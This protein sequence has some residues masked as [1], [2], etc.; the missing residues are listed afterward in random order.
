MRNTL[1]R[2]STSALLA[3]LL[4][5][6]CIDGDDP[7]LEEEGSEVPEAE[8]I[9]PEPAVW[10][11]PRPELDADARR[12]Q[13]EVDRYVRDVIYRGYS[14]VET[15]Q[16]YSGDIIDWV[17]PR[18]VPGSEIEPPPPLAAAE[19]PPG[20]ELQ[21]TELDEHPY[22][23][24]PAGSIP[25]VRP[26]FA[27]YVREG[28]AAGSLASYLDAEEASQSLAQIGNRLYAG[29]DKNTPNI[30]VD[31]F[32]TQNI[33]QIEPGTFSLLEVATYCPGP[34]YKTTAEL[35]GM[36]V[37]KD[38]VNFGDSTQRLR[39]EFL[40]KGH[41][42]G[43]YVGGWDGK[44]KGLIAAPGRPY[45]P[46]I[47]LAQGPQYESRFHIQNYS[48]NWWIAHNNN[49]LGYYPGS[50]FDLITFQGCKAQFYGEVYDSTPSVW[51]YTDMGSGY[52]PVSGLGKAAHMRNP[53]YTLPS[54]QSVWLDAFAD[55]YP[56]INPEC[57]QTSPVYSAAA[58]WNV[59]FLLGGAGNNI[60][61]CH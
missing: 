24:G 3:A 18:T 22:L 28:S 59:Y 12:R 8:E 57:Y 34:S 10:R 49:W 5:S 7:F 33:E 2:T 20:V 36:T 48:G 35:V 32:V 23:R 58:P 6:G 46:N 60:F 41:Q 17:D 39:V 42:S 56:G 14:I 13:R 29:Y 31:A 52:Y 47:A 30:A 26:R 61:G 1:I 19:L 43:H 27:S 9:L 4:C 37:S 15:T 16:M 40:T 55:L 21:P 25:F 54:G 50:L 11:A 51:T 38:M 53:Y 44:Y 45:A